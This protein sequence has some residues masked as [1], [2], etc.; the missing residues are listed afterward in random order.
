MQV[1]IT[2]YPCSWKKNSDTAPARVR[3]LYFLRKYRAF[4]YIGPNVS[5]PSVELFH[6]NSCCHYIGAPATL[7]WK[8]L[9]QNSTLNQDSNGSIGRYHHYFVFIFLD[10]DETCL[11]VV[12]A[13]SNCAAIKCEISDETNSPHTK[14]YYYQFIMRFIIFGFICV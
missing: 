9:W 6:I 7:L 2:I 5:E 8:L 11:M 13:V 1:S 4:A 3:V 10:K 14:L 12:A